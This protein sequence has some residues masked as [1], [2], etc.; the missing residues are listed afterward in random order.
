MKTINQFICA[1]AFLSSGVLH[2]QEISDSVNLEKSYATE[3]YYSLENG[4]IKSSPRVD[5]DLA[6]EITG[7]TSTIRIN[8]G[9]GTQVYLYPNGDISSWATLDT[10][11]ISTWAPLNGDYTSWANGELTSTLDQSNAFDLGWGVYNQTTHV[12]TGDS[13]FVLK[14]SDGTWKKLW[15]VKLQSGTYSFKYADLDHNNEKEKTIKKGDF[16]NRNFGYFS[17]LNEKQVDM[18]P[19]NKDWD[20]V[21]TKYIDALSPG[22]YYGVTGALCNIGVEV[23]QADEVDVSTVDYSIQTFSET[24]NI[25]GHDWKSFDLSTYKYIVQDS[26]AYFVK[27]LSGN[28]W[29]IIF[30]GFAG[31]STGKVYFTKEAVHFVN[32]QEIASN[33]YLYTYPN[34]ISPNAS[35]IN[36]HSNVEEDFEIQLL[37]INGKVLYANRKNLNLGGN[38][39]AL[40]EGLS[41]GI[42]FVR[43][44][45]DD[46]QFWNKVI[47]K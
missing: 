6:F 17:I 40:K 4:V 37:D 1:I 44:I 29:K 8:G 31:S 23:A 11:G 13:L 22:V 36:I 9:T 10:S 47:V 14:L 32:V 25:I 24:P 27:D 42:Y 46:A 20:I 2:A 28:T 16:E 33:K 38:S 5:W 39:I 7:I 43:I 34:P 12:V 21:F 35:Q 30:T 18:E 26:L 19:S 45:G 15:I 3:I 41:Q